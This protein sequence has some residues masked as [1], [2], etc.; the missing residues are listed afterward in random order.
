MCLAPLFCNVQVF[1]DIFCKRINGKIYAM[2]TARYIKVRVHRIR[3]NRT[4]D[5]EARR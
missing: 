3:K 1:S 4:F 5:T 2:L